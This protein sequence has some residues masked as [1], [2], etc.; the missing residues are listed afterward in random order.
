MAT[1]Q[2]PQKKVS[3]NTYVGQNQPVQDELF[4]LTLQSN[5]ITASMGGPLADLPAPTRFRRILDIG[6]GSGSWIIET[7]RKYPDVSLVGIDISE[8]MVKYAREQAALHQVSD[9]VEFHVMDVLRMLEFPDTSFDLVNLR[10][11]LSFLRTWDWSKL[12]GETLRVTRPKGLLRVTDTELVQPSTSSALMQLNGMSVRSF[13]RAGHLFAEDTTGLTAHLALLLT[14][15]GYRQVETKEYQLEY[16]AGTVEGEMFYE[17]MK[18]V[19]QA[20]YPFF[21]KWGC[22]PKNYDE[23]YQQAL[24]EMQ[25]PEFKTTWKLLS[26][27]GTNL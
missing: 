7:A 24:E 23:I 1:P 8:Q 15:H 18:Y 12:L 11:G 25:L 2:E 16:Q 20:L 17:D 10:L 4:R 9:R 27:W 22:A 5:L 13:F 3:P 19:F 21:K 6:S 14:R 26:A